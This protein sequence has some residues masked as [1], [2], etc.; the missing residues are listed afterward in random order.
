MNGDVANLSHAARW[1]RDA[2]ESGQITAILATLSR[3]PSLCVLVVVKKTSSIRPDIT[4][5]G[6]DLGTSRRS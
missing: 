5:S 6:E 4:R 1:M 2:E 3:S